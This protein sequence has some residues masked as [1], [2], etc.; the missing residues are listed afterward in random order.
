MHEIHFL[1][2]TVILR[3]IED[4]IDDDEAVGEL[5]PPHVIRIPLISYSCTLILIYNLPDCIVNC[6]ICQMAQDLRTGINSRILAR[7][8]YDS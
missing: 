5:M 4:D 2:I 7:C 3:A 1:G 6:Q 8:F